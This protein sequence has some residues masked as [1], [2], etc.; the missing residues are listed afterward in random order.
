[1][2]PVRG[3]AAAL[4]ALALALWTLG[5]WASWVTAPVFGPRTSSRLRLGIMRRWARGCLAIFGA[6]VELVGPPPSPPFLL[7]SNHLGYLDVIVLASVAPA[8][9][10]SRA[11]VA[12][13]PGIG[14]IARSAGTL[15]IDRAAKRDLPKVIDRVRETFEAGHGVIFFPEGTSSGGADV[16]PFK[17][18]L[19]EFAAAGGLPVHCAS[20]AFERPAA[21]PPAADTVC[22]WADMTF[23]G[24]AWGLLARPGWSA[25]IAFAEGPVTAGDR[26]QLAAA[27]ERA[28]RGLFVPTDASRGVGAPIAAGDAR[29]RAACAGP[30]GEAPDPD[31]TGAATRDGDP[32]D[33]DGPGRATP[34][35]PA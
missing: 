15:F 9:F 14:P 7:V 26:K 12:D 18:S 27:A 31:G 20:L 30:G 22:W 3:L 10:L 11:D 34:G 2:G 29:D 8:R 5:A 25:R 17:A 16:L 32:T 35:D 6:R 21:R 23:G 13:W 1:M 19:F 28:V 4:R 24:H 33:A